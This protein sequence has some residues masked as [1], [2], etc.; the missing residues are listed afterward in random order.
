MDPILANIAKIPGVIA[1]GLFAPNDT[2]AG[3]TTNEAGYEPVILLTAIHAAEEALNVFRTG[4]GLH[5]AFVFSLELEHG[6]FLY[7]RAGM[8]RLAVLTT[9]SVNIAVIEVAINAATLKLAGAMTDYTGVGGAAFPAYPTMGGVGSMPGVAMGGGMGQMP[10][11]PGV[12]NMSHMTAMGMNPMFPQPR[13]TPS[14]PIPVQPQRPT[15]SQSVSKPPG[16]PSS[17]SS[18][19]VTDTWTPE[20]LTINGSRARGSVGP[21]VMQHVLKALSRY[22]GINAKSI[23]VEELSQLNATPATVMP[24]IF[25]DFI[26]NLAARIPD[27]GVQDEFIGIALG[28]RK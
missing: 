26:Y 12:P 11:T 28:D 23:I 13:M 7:R 18:S 14:Q 9:S 27:P 21:A 8:S 25:T 15:G 6:Y 16:F 5:E 17:G 20:E 10:G 3:F 4:D 19:G 24:A 1:A 2:C 22:V